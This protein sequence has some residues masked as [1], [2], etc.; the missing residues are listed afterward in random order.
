MEKETEKQLDP[1]AEFIL[2]ALS[3]QASLAPVDIAR[4]L[5]EQRRRASDKPE[6][7]RRFM[8][9][10]KQ[11]MLH[12]ARA[13]MIEIVRKGEVVDPEDFRGVVRMRLKAGD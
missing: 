11:Q 12:L 5:G 7:W 2:D 3:A 10:V 9:P 4:A 13:G 6:A 8:M 1:V